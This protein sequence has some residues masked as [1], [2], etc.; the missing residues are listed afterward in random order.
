MSASLE[1][2]ALA[3]WWRRSMP[4]S[5]RYRLIIFLIAAVSVA[6]LIQGLIAYRNALHETD[7][8]F[9]YH[10]RQMAFSMQGR[11]GSGTVSVPLGGDK[12][13]FDFLVQA[14]ALD[15][16][17]LLESPLGGLLPQRAV[18]GFSNVD[19][20]GRQYRVFS[21]QTSYQ[22]IQVAQDMAVRRRMA[23]ELAWRTVLPI[24]LMLPLLGVVVWWVVSHSLEPVSRVRE[25]I[26]N[27]A[28][29]DLAPLVAA[30]MPSELGPLVAEFNAL[31]HRV[32]GAFEAQQHF[33]ADAAHELRSPLTA[34]KLQLQGLQ[35]ATDAQEQAQAAA[36]LAKG[37]DRASHLVDQLLALA[38]Q[39]GRS[40]AV[41]GA[42]DVAL[43]ALC[44][45]AVVAVADAAGAKGIDL[46]LGRCDAAQVRG[47]S[48]SL[49]MLIR[50]LLD[51]AIK[52]T[53]AGGHV[54]LSLRSEGSRTV[55][56]CVEDS[57]PGIAS[58]ERERVFDR[59]YRSPETTALAGAQGSGLGLAIV[60]AIADSHGA[61]ITLDRSPTLG[62]LWVRI[63]FPVQA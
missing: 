1:R 5:L 48:E 55:V 56:L 43:D 54:D 6:A 27:R 17:P 14:W 7:E 61:T 8:I 49:A 19:S 44:R 45:D 33:V 42:H 58:A 35:R 41:L 18:L 15:G 16:S 11:F 34:L 32:A 13:P 2:S 23:G 50:N 26:A 51:N 20:Y 46:G 30:D 52:Y 9:D 22:V 39:E 25:Q 47:Q 12:Q 38:R 37:I 10:M 36:R 28:A 4:L 59:F 62:G 53:P 24:A 40:L 63:V 60:R 21:L 57:G 31:L 29:D 3:D